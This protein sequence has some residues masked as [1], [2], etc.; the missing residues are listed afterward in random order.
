MRI[1]IVRLALIGSVLLVAGL[2]AIA[3]FV[4]LS[5]RLAEAS[6]LAARADQ[7][8]TANLTM[9]NQYN[10]ALDQA[11]QAPQAAADAQVLFAKMP[12]TAELP[13]VL[14]QIT[15]AAT[16][17]GI[18][19]SAV[20]TLTTGIPVPAKAAGDDPTAKDAT[21]VQLAQMQIGVTAEGTRPQVL[22]FLT[23]LQ[24][25]DRALLVNSTQVSIVP[26]VDGG[27][28][29]QTVQVGGSMFALQSK[30]PDLVALVDQL[31]TEAQSS[32]PSDSGEDQA[33][34]E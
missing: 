15:Q 3:W 1:G 34:A 32:A 31:L 28:G 6:D 4:V 21:G 29:L 23:N 10:R 14:D 17:A 30:L 13:A 22:A 26:E 11:A 18:D 33:T 9:L 16:S 5:P 24:A 12:Q 27:G 7:M 20:S 19:P 8:Q 25:L 2:A